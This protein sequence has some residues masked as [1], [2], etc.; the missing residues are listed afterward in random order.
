MEIAQ[1]TKKMVCTEEKNITG[2]PEGEKRQHGAKPVSK[3]KIAKNFSKIMKRQEVTD[4][5]TLSSNQ[6]KL[7]PLH[8]TEYDWWKSKIYIDYPENSY[9]N[10]HTILKEG[11]IRWI[12][13]YSIAII[14]VWKQGNDILKVLKITAYL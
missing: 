2:I 8:M 6:D 13:N 7:S 10:T 4:S 9:R 11:T 3:R 12:S 5:R 1:R 14:K